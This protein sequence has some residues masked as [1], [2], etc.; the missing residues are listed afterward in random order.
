MAHPGPVVI[1]VRADF[2]GRLSTHTQLARAVAT[3]Q[4]LLGPMNAAELRCAITEPARA[5]GLRLDAGLVEV[6][7]RDVAGEPGA[8]PLLSHA[9]RATWELR[10]G[11]TLTVDGYR[12]TGGVSSAIARTAD[13]IVQTTPDE[14]HAL[15]RSVFLRL[16]E[17][18]GGVEDTRR[19]VDIDE[20]VP[21]GGS[22]AA[23]TALLKRLA[24]ARLVTLREG[25]AEVAHEALIRAWPALRTWLDEDHEGLRLHRRLGD[26]AR[27]WAAGGHETSDLYRGTRL[28]AAREWAHNNPEALNATERGF[29]DASLELADRERAD[30]ARRVRRLRRL[31]AGVALALVVALVAGTF[32]LVQR[33]RASRA[34]DRAESQAEVADATRLAAQ[35]TSLA[36]K[37]LDLALNLA[38]EAH[39]LHATVETEGALET[40]L[41]AT[42]PGLE[43]L[44]HFDPPAT[45]AGISN[46]GG[47]LAAPGHDG[48]VRLIATG[49]GHEVRRLVGH[50]TGALLATFTG[51]DR[52]LAAGGDDGLVIVW[53]VATGR[54]LGPP[55]DA[56]GGPASGAFDPTDGT[57]LYTAGHDGA[58]TAWNLT[59]PEQPQSV[60]LFRVPPNQNAD[61]PVVVLINS[62]GGRLLVGDPVL[63]PSYIWDVRSG[64]LLGVVPGVPGGWSP[65]GSTVA[66][67][68]GAEVVLVD[69][70]TGAQQ[71]QAI[72]GFDFVVPVIAFSPDGQR[73]AASDS[74]GTVRVFDLATRQEATT[75]ALHDDLALPQFLADGRLFTRSSRLAAITRLDATAIAP[76]AAPPRPLLGIGGANDL[77]AS[78]PRTTRRGRRRRGRRR[79]GCRSGALIHAPSRGRPPLLT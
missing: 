21:E 78:K 68:R 52:H 27:L 26:A 23:V 71:G 2:Y 35:A 41:A 70:A 15:L 36:G 28:D 1:G 31:L 11:R 67:G 6:I 32:A 37:R 5:A 74:D 20:L 22:T 72:T 7:L 12:D 75:L 29:L 58:V 24:D 39:H 76:I 59:D 9:L 33:F 48:A 45:F 30:Q 62:D 57:R 19:R 61:L 79:G 4:I 63:G 18:G 42:P 43:R 51:D 77:S 50:K 8:L 25:T 44:V 65:D 47:L 10:D 56:G 16:T 3:N 17:I 73:L 49:S 69:A 60:E 53:D 14:L 34:A 55:L 38:V 54:R 13:R 46:D 40:V 66:I 64:A